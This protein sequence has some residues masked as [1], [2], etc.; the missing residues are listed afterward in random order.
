LISGH[1]GGWPRFVPDLPWR[2]FLCCVEEADDKNDRLPHV[3]E[4][5]KP[6]LLPAWSQL[7]HIGVPIRAGVGE[8]W[9]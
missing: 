7:L 4:M 5:K 2:C 1:C 6:A 3:L 9:L 8:S